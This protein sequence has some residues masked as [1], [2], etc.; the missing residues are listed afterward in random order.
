[1]YSVASIQQ[2]HQ[3]VI[4]EENVIHGPPHGDQRVH[5][6]AQ[7][8]APDLNLYAVVHKHPRQ[9]KVELDHQNEHQAF[10][11]MPTSSAADSAQHYAV[12][13]EQGKR[14]GI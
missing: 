1:M 11:E 5:D 2:S 14:P 3:R 4:S 13:N 7:D 8:R 6:F 9:D 12:I 10:N